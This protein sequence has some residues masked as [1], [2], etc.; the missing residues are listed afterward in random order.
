MVGMTPRT[1]FGYLDKPVRVRG[2]LP[3]GPSVALVGTRSASDEAVRF[4]YDLA[5][6]LCASGVVVWSGGALGI[7]AA[8]HRGAMAGGGPTVVVLGCGVEAVYPAEHR[9]L[10]AEVVASGGALVSVTEDQGPA[11]RGYF[12]RR[13]DL[14]AAATLATVVIQAGFRSGARSTAA[15]A[16]RYKRPLFAVPHAPWD[17]AGQGC[18]LELGLGAVP[19]VQGP[20]QLCK[21]L[22]IR[23]REPTRESSPKQLNLGL[24]SAVEAAIIKALSYRAQNIEQLIENTEYFAPAIREGLLTLT[25]AN[26]V[27]E[28]APGQFRLA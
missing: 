27:V 19:L 9:D 5:R 7:D 6:D 25:L 15:F 20:R 22:G 11:L 18:C 10:F 26:V 3:L 17:E 13:N 14:L 2:A 1:V 12:F 24:F 23:F 16:R 21:T 8:A 28:A 4:T